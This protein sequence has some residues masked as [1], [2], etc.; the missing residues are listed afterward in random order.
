MLAT[1][2]EVLP[3]AKR[4]HYAVGLFN[5]VTLEMAKGVLAAAEELGSPVIIGSAE[6]LLPY[7]S[8]KELASFLLPMAEE[9]TVPVVLHFDHGLTLEKVHEA[10]DLGFRSVMYD[11]STLDFEGNCQAVAG[12]VKEAHA[13]GVTIEAELGHVGANAGGG[14]D[15]V[16][17]Q[18]QEAV[19]F[20]RRT[21]VDALAVAIGTA[22][23]AYRSAPKLDIPRLRE[24]AQAVETPLVLH[25]GSGLSVQNFQDCI[26]A[27][28]AKVNIF[29]DLDVAAAKA[30]HDGWQPGMGMTSLMGPQAQAVKAVVLEKMGIFGS[31]GKAR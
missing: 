10:M 7:A 6:I 25:G 16:F 3:R 23:G 24:I 27:G 17:T 11:C 22:H 18:P 21:G 31:A 13:R 15:S 12:L 20:C 28:I 4:E 19:E 5:T 30:V 9:A 8:L 2:K 1:L 26:Q 14:D 29:T